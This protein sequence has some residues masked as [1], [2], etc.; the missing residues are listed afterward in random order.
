MQEKLKGFGVMK[1]IPDLMIFQPSGP[2]C[3][4]AIELKVVYDSGAKNRLSPSQ[5]EAMKILEGSR[6]KC[7]TVWTYEEFVSEIKKYFN[8]K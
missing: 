1:G 6:W 2:Y 8:K 7:V 4:L 3:G 5:K